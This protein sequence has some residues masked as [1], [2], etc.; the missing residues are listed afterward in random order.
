MKRK[1]NFAKALYV[2]ETI[3]NSNCK[4]EEGNAVICQQLISASQITHT[5]LQVYR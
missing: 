3:Y 5:F 2:R 1:C 4:L